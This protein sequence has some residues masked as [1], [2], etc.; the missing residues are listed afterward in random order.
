M[1]LDPDRDPFTQIEEVLRTVVVRLLLI[2]VFF[3][4][5]GYLVG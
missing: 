3:F 5:L 1:R 4:C 2:A